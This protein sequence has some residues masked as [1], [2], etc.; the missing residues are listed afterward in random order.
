MQTLI[1]DNI[2]KIRKA[3]E[4]LE[5]KLNI[6][7]NITGKKIEFSGGA[8]EEY[9]AEKILRAIDFGFTIPKAMLIKEQE[10]EFDIIH[11]KNYSR[12]QDLRPVRARII[13]REG[14]T[15]KTLENISGSYLKINDGEVGAIGN[16][17]SIENVKTAITKLIRRTKQ[18]NTYRY[19][20]K[21]N[22]I[23]KLERN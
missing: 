18:A 2:G 4:M 3:K 8:I 17:E 19:L 11:I 20:E 22:R 16:I 23:K 14:R 1:I 9:E 7:I 12:K 10:L 13:G 6:K 15:R 21:T 5:K